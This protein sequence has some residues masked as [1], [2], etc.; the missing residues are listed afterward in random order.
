MKYQ[1]HWAHSAFMPRAKR[2]PSLLQPPPQASHFIFHQYC[3]K[4]SQHDILFQV[5]MFPLPG[6]ALPSLSIWKAPTCPLKPSCHLFQKAF[7]ALTQ[8]AL[9][10]PTL[11]PIIIPHTCFPE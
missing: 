7:P 10:S 3:L 9:K 11:L 5:W 1:G 8:T 6:M 2:L 4:L